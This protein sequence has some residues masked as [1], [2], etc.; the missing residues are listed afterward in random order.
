MSLMLC[1]INM[2]IL[3]Q[4]E[5]TFPRGLYFSHLCPRIL[6]SSL[7][8]EH[9]WYGKRNKIRNYNLFQIASRK[10]TLPFS[11]FNNIDQGDYL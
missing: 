10:Q 11:Q 7:S 6:L 2:Q 9:S 5:L 4:E 1:Y 3:P 8:T